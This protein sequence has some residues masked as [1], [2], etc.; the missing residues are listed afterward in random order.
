[1]DTNETLNHMETNA[2]QFATDREN[3]AGIVHELE[4]E[5]LK[6]KQRFMNKIKA[7]ANKAAAS[8]ESLLALV[9]SNPEMF[10]DPKSM[11][12]HGVRFGYQKGRGKIDMPN[13]EYTIGKIEQRFDD[14]IGALVK[15]TKKVIKNGLLQLSAADAK[16]IGI[17][18]TDTDLKAYV[19]TS[20]S[21]VDKFVDRL[22]TEMDGEE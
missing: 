12:L 19:K 20:D 1:M 15:T 5:T 9:E 17:T 6:L 16:A 13:E 8:R 11:N 21:A 2:K 7:A 22:I 18:I 4:S 3:L 10:E 14:E